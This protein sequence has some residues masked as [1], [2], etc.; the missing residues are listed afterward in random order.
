MLKKILKLNRKAFTL[1]EILLAVGLTAIAAVSIGAI[2]MSTQN[3]TTKLFGETEL[4]QQI[5]EV[6][7]SVRNDILTTNAGIKFWVKDDNGAYIHTLVDKNNSSEKILALYNLDQEDYIMTG[8]YY[9]YDATNKELHK[10]EV[11]FDD[12][13]VQKDSTKKNIVTVDQNIGTRIREFE[14]KNEWTLI[15]TDLSTFNIDLTK[16]Q[17]Q[18]LVVFSM[19][20]VNEGSKHP[21]EDTVYIRND[22]NVNED[23]KIDEYHT[24]KLSKP[25]LENILFTYDGETHGPGEINYD[26]ALSRYIIRSAES[27]LNAKD[28]GVYYVRYSLKNSVTSTW[29]D[30]ST[31]DIIVQ[32][33]IKP[34]EVG[35][36][37]GETEWVYDGLQ[38]KATCTPTNVVNGDDCGLK[39]VNDV[40]GPDVGTKICTA[41]VNNKNYVVPSVYETELKIVGNFPTVDIEIANHTYNGQPQSMV[42]Y[43]NLV[44]GTLR[45]YISKQSAEPTRDQMINSSCEATN[46]GDYYIWYQLLATD[47]N[48][49]NSG[50]I[51][52]GIAHM[53]RAPGAKVEIIKCE[54]N[55]KEQSGV[56]PIFAQVKDGIV[57]AVEAGTYEIV[58]IPDEN[59]TW[60]DDCTTNEKTF[61]WTIEK[62]DV[63]LTAPKPLDLTFNG[64]F[65]ALCEPGITSH[66]TMLYKLENG[67]WSEEIPLGF[68]AGDYKVYYRSSGDNNHNSTSEDAF[69]EVTIKRLNAAS[70]VISNHVYDATTATGY[71]GENVTV[72]GVKASTSVGKYDISAVPKDNY[73]WSDTGTTERRYYSWYILKADV[74]ITPPTPRELIYNGDPQTLVTAGTVELV[75]ANYT[76][77][78]GEMLYKLEGDEEWSNSI[79]TATNAGTYNVYYYYP[80]NENHNE[81]SK[82]AF[83]TVTIGRDAQATAIPVD[84]VYN[85]EVQCGVEGANVIWSGDDNG[86]EV[87]TYIAYATPDSNHTWPDGSVEAK[88]IIWTITRAAINAPYAL[89]VTYNEELQIGVGGDFIILS[90]DYE[91]ID[92]GDY[93]AYAEPDENHMWLDGT[94]EA[95]EVLWTMKRAPGAYIDIIDR[96]Y[97]EEEQCGFS[98]FKFLTDWSGD[99]TAINAGYYSFTVRP[100]DNHLWRDLKTD[101]QITFSW[102]IE[103]AKGAYIVTEDKTYTGS[104]Q[105]GFSEKQFVEFVSGNEKATN[106][107]VYTF[108]AVPDSNHVWEDDSTTDEKEFSWTMNRAVGASVT[109]ANRTYNGET[110]NGYSSYSNCTL[111]GDY[112]AK[113]AKNYSFYAT[114]D[115]NH[116]WSDGSIERKPFTWTMGRS[117]TAWASGNGSRYAYTGSYITGVSG[118]GVT[119]SGNTGGTG[120]S[121]YYAY[122]TPDANH[123]WTD[124]TTGTVTLIWHIYE[125][126]IS[127]GDYVY[128]SS[129]ARTWAQ[130][131]GPR[132]ND[133]AQYGYRGEV[134][135]GTGRYVI[136]FHNGSKVT[137][138]TYSSAHAGSFAIGLGGSYCSNPGASNAWEYIGYWGRLGQ[139]HK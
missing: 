126:G 44:G 101:E 94:I 32:W 81:S 93:V 91:A 67:D 59:H 127:C 107:G 136:Y 75:S 47:S 36:A 112:A 132:T 66:G 48:Y 78:Y 54:Y 25:S 111:S 135:A 128:A 13:T 96:V 95:K 115:S 53:D 117:A 106:A 24:V 100:D 79:P 99:Y 56:N 92:A 123:A 39:L 3:N 64:D 110:Q 20:V 29:D 83:V 37:W 55:G 10:A 19:A 90:G 103:R 84:K 14:T 42:K 85:G 62:A 104:E 52:L 69:I 108:T 138:G 9:K 58:A 12:G 40:I 120:C 70:V 68:D 137:S 16:Y 26:E 38:H 122:A 116:T 118:A 11:E 21:K 80:G 4:H 33:E 18:E 61:V 72:T 73:S 43:N 46:A 130:A 60:E 57:N 51:Y 17:D 125:V 41:T 63:E 89:D 28:A 114:P 23:L 109:T 77:K 1:V 22:I 121:T 5:N 35:L 113:D 98:D 105:N 45:F 134:A 97:N 65:Q 82:D 76:D 74:I 27:T 124:G 133:I 88:E 49:V 131:A 30:G 86:K 102:F 50:V 15:A 139:W 87:G 34:R 7:E 71:R 8:T 129:G 119:W 2:I 31:S 6:K